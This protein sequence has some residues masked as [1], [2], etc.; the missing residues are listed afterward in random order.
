MSTVLSRPARVAVAALALLT[1]VAGLTTGTGR[2]SATEDYSRVVA[3]VSK[4][5]D[6]PGP[7]Y[8]LRVANLNTL[9]TLSDSAFLAQ[10]RVLRDK[11]PN[12]ILLQEVAERTV[13]LRDWAR[14]NGYRIYQ[15]GGTRDIWKNASVVLW[16]DNGRFRVLGYENRLGSLPLTRPG[17][18]HVGTRYLT[19]VRLRDKLSGQ[20]LAFTSTHATPDVY[21][22]TQDGYRPWWGTDTLTWFRRH[23]RAVRELVIANRAHITVLGGDFNAPA[24]HEHQWYGFPTH[25]FGDL[26]ESNH[27]ALGRVPTRGGGAIDYVFAT[28]TRRIGFFRQQI[29]DT[30]SDHNAMIMDFRVAVR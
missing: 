26:L 28:E 19:T 27:Q 1:V 12:V 11:R 25:R 15:P 3:D 16:K 20:P 2:A 10:M 17:G 29:L 5:A 4:P 13:V 9:F 7:S 14:R 18:G 8:S 23:M 6:V 30:Y 21:L 24:R 22:R